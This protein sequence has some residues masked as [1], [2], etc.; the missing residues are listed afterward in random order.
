MAT[1]GRG[2][3]EILA[4]ASLKRLRGGF[5]FLYFQAED[6][7]DFLEIFPDFAFCWRIAQQIRGVIG[8]QQFSSAKFQPLPAKL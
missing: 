3:N 4:A 7:H 6:G 8:R 1:E 5:A 2:A